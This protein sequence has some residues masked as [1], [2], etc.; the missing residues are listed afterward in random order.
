MIGKLF[1]REN[2]FCFDAWDCDTRAELLLWKT[3]EHV[4]GPTF[5]VKAESREDAEGVYKI[6]AACYSA[7]VCVPDATKEAVQ[8]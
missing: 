6:L 5:A 4:G 1:A 2:R 3:I 8:S 7:V